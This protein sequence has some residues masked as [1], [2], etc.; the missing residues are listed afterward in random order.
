[1]YNVYK[2]IM[3]ILF[4]SSLSSGSDDSFIDPFSDGWPSANGEWNQDQLL[5]KKRI[6]Q[7]LG[8]D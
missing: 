2:C 5:T 3:Y 8:W 4:I 1:M 7:E 6:R